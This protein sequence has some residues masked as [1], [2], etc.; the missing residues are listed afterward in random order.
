MTK[1]AVAFFSPANAPN[2]AQLLLLL[3]LKCDRDTPPSLICILVQSNFSKDPPHIKHMNGSPPICIILIS[4]WKCPLDCSFQIQLIYQICTTEF[5]AT[6]IKV[7]YPPPSFYLNPLPF[8]SPVRV[9]RK[10]WLESFAANWLTSF[11]HLLPTTVAKWL[12]N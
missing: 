1:L 5:T 7:R 12:S 11:H 6:F 4:S 2:N 3:F 9:K 8:A 10:L